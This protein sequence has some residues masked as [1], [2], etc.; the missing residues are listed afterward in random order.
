MVGVVN[1][2]IE[3]QSEAMT[4]DRL[5]RNAAGTKTTDEVM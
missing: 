3:P 1:R 5:I 2:D 4:S